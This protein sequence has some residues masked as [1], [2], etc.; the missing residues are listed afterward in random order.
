MDSLPYG[1]W[2]NP[3]KYLRIFQEEN[4]LNS[5]TSVGGLHT[6]INEYTGNVKWVKEN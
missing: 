4:S 6:A 2:F 3:R 5:L 1:W